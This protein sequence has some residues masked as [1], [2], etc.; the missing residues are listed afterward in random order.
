MRYHYVWLIWSSAFL[1]PWAVLYLLNPRLR[2]MMWRTSAVTALLGLTEPLFVPR[3]WDPPSLLDLAART[4]FDIESVIFAFAVGG[5]GAVL[6]TTLTRQDL[7]PVADHDRHA[8]RHR[9]HRAALIGPI[10]L[11][12]VLFLLPWNPIYPS[13]FALV[14]G[15]VAAVLCRPDLARRTLTGGFLFLG[16]YVVFMLALRWSAPGYIEQVW[17]LDAL[18][19]VLIAGVPLEELLFG[20]S[21]GMYWSSVYEHVTWHRGAGH[22]AAAVATS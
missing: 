6:Y 20:F 19:G 10:L 17:N 8:R 7:A 15:A 13:V 5:I 21:F 1:V 18:S 3:Y 14:V 16:L 2:G 11:L 4:G 12:V 22:H 9:F